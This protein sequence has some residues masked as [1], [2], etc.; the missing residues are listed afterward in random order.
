M[1][2]G[3]VSSLV[4]LSTSQQISL[5][6]RFLKISV[7]TVILLR[8]RRCD[9]ITPY[10]LVKNSHIQSNC[11]VLHCAPKRKTF[12]SFVT[13]SCSILFPN[14]RPHWMRNQRCASSG[15]RSNTADS[16][17]LVN[18]DSKM[19][20]Y[21]S[22]ECL[23]RRVTLFVQHFQQHPNSP[24]LSIVVAGGGGHLLSTLAATP[25]ASAILLEGTT[26]YSRKAF[27][28]F[29]Q[30]EMTFKF[31]QTFKYCS[32]EAVTALSDAACRRAL[33]LF[34]TEVNGSSPTSACATDRNW[35]NILRGA[36]GVAATSTLQSSAVTGQNAD[37]S[38][39]RSS[40]RSVES[41]G[42][43]AF[44][45]V[46]TSTGL[47]IQIFA[48]LIRDKISDADS[49]PI[50]RSRFDEDVFVSHCLLTCIQLSQLNDYENVV[51][52]LGLASNVEFSQ[53]DEDSE[54]VIQWKSAEGDDF[55]VRIPSSFVKSPIKTKTAI[56]L[57]MTLRNAAKR[58]L[59]ENDKVVTILLPNGFNNTVEVLHTTKLPPYSLVIPGSFNPP[60][61]GHMLLAQAAAKAMDRHCS[62]IWFELSITNADK[63]ALAVEAIV[64]RIKY[65]FEYREKMPVDMCWGILL[66][67]AP[68]FKQK[69]DLL[70]PLQ[71]DQT[72]SF[73]YFSIGTDTLVRLID[74]KYYNNSVEEMYETLNQ[75]SCH[76]I[77]GGRLDQERVE[78]SIFISG[79]EVIY[80]LPSELRSKFTIIPDFRVDLSSTEI[81]N[82]MSIEK[83]KNKNT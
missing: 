36:V 44:C 29:I 59:E 41:F 56:C 67:N 55:T 76:F 11:W 81:R 28:D 25:G 78:K 33:F 82:K 19:I 66:T 65:F 5:F 38:P 15:L 12:V 23:Q 9:C 8:I 70:A 7:F 22:L 14:Q 52:L 30:R 37:G 61:V 57:D 39:I 40:R 34:A 63:P 3:K 69:L 42:S 68:L 10:V 27:Q 50:T 49:C 2:Q 83:N 79:D 43:R 53:R 13:R 75:M 51:D 72:A 26:P 77:V 17:F 32:A 62:S 35:T 1:V 58:I 21:C 54:I 80:K 45:A 74:P 20:D 64:E 18:A 71:I 24:K 47:Q 6:H 60:H 31:A 48:Q 4:F 73:L 46:Q 16:S